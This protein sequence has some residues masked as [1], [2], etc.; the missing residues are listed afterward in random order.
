MVVHI[1]QVLAAVRWP[2]DSP[3]LAQLYLA[4]MTYILMDQVSLPNQV[5]GVPSL[6]AA[7][8]MILWQWYTTLDSQ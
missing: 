8:L 5:L 4:L 7:Q 3:T 6:S 2:L 1:Q